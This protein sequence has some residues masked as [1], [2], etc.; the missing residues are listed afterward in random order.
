MAGISV[1]RGQGHGIANIDGEVVAQTEP[2]IG[3]EGEAWG[4]LVLS[5]KEHLLGWVEEVLRVGCFVSF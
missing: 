2:A 1:A 4:L 5:L 3:Q